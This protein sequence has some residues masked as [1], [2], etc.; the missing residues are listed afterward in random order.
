M[1]DILCDDV[2]IHGM[3]CVKVF[4]E[5]AKAAKDQDSS[6]LW[7]KG[8]CCH[9]FRIITM[10]YIVVPCEKKL[11]DTPWDVFPYNLKARSF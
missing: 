2:W 3:M 5:A 6:G 8:P 7:L 4:K 1:A 11:L 9:G 10:G